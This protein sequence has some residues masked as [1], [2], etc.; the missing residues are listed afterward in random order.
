[1]SAIVI[2]SGPNGLAAAVTLARAGV[3]VI[4]VEAADTIGGGARS[5]ELTLSGFVHDVGSAVHPLAVHSGFFRRFELQR[6]IELLTP[7]I[8]FGHPLERGEALLAWRSL[9][10]TAGE[11]GADGRGYRRLLAPLAAR[12][13][14]IAQLTG[15]PLG[16]LPKHFPTTVRFGL[17]V[18]ELRNQ[19]SSLGNA[20]RTLLAGCAA[21][22]IQPLETIGASAA[23]LTLATYAHA[24]GWPIPRGGSGAI[25]AALRADLEAH[26][27]RIETGRR[28]DALSELPGASVVLFDTSARDMSRIAGDEINPRYLKALRRMR[29]GNAA[30]KVDFALSGPV[31]WIDQRLAE[32]V[33]LH[34][35]GTAA[36][37]AAA[38]RQI[39]R[40]ELPSKPYVLLAQPTAL[41]SSRAPAGRHV[42]WAYTHV[43][44]GSNLDP[45]ELITAQIE[46]FAPGF[47]DLVLASV[48]TSALQLAADNPNYVA[49]DIAAGA[50]TARQLFAR[51]VTG[52]EPWFAGSA[53][54]RSL[55]LCS[56]SAAPG[57]G[58][59]GLGGYYAARSALRRDF[60]VRSAPQL[61][62]T[63]AA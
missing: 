13:D 53:S 31:P 34:L 8:S 25:V 16:T 2:G 52:P 4:V 58:V 41:D 33:T 7:E 47:R 57:P 17:G 10:R 60:G 24:R 54:G 12:A 50:P 38:E 59:H 44:A 21:H 39:A 11:L 26:G 23:A 51:P 9:E 56:A 37:I 42:V 22:P 35:G 29:Y 62:L 49:G 1:M 45:T 32:A 36:E 14:A 40:G 30:A 5:A 46:R 6:R 19:A 18:L 48:A 63:N 15:S 27:G 3:P 55:Y 28:I 43:P 20:A 61:G